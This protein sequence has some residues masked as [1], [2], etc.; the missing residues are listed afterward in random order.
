MSV[1][2][3]HLDI[4]RRGKL[5]ALLTTLVICLNM[6]SC[7]DNSSNQTTDVVDETLSKTYLSIIEE[8]TALMNEPGDG[9]MQLEKIRAYVQSNTGRLT[10]EIGVINSGILDLDDTKRSA[11]LAQTTPKIEASLERFAQAQ[12]ALRARMTESEQW[13]LGEALGMFR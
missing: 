6:V 7:H 9:A 13:E 11:L 2:I 10:Q 4:G 5:L 12:I 3:L 1:S 8:M